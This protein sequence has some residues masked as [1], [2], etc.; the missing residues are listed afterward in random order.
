MNKSTLNR[1]QLLEYAA[2]S[3]KAKNV[4]IGLK[5]TEEEG[6]RL[7]YL[8]ELNG[9]SKSEIIRESLYTANVHHFKG[10]KHERK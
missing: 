7:E 9:V 4:N 8:S 3:K 6:K 10:I 1:E 2:L 5:L